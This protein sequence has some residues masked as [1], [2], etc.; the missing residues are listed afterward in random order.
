MAFDQSDEE[1]WPDQQKDTD[2]ENYKDMERGTLQTRF[3]KPPFFDV[4]LPEKL[5]WGFNFFAFF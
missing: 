5:E 3:L 4:P 2:K 1:T